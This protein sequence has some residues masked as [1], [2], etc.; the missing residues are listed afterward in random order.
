MKINLQG[1]DIWDWVIA[2]V[3]IAL[4]GYI[5]YMLL[6][7]YGVLLGIAAGAWMIYQAKKRRDSLRKKD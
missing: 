3:F 7:P 1:M 5:F 6:P 4:L 2:A